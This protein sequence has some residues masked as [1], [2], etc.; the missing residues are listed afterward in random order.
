VRNRKRA[1]LA[2]RRDPQRLFNADLEAAREAGD[3]D[4]VA[5][6]EALGREH[7]FLAKPTPGEALN[8]EIRAAWRG[9]ADNVVRGRTRPRLL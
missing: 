4:L 9:D 2:A 3:K 8:E 1:R 6:L 5:R 7:G